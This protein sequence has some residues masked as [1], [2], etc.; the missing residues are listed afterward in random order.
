VPARNHRI[1]AFCFVA[2]LAACVFGYHPVRTPV[3]LDNQT[4]FY[5][6]ERAASGVPP[7]VSVV[8]HKHALSHLLSAGAIVAGR[9]A[10][11]DDV[12]AARALSIAACAGTVA[13]VAALALR[14]T[15][16]SAAGFLAGLAMLT[17]SGFLRQATMGFRP[18]LFATLFL[19]WAVVAACDRKHARA[20]AY[21]ACAFL[22]WQPAGVVI[23][24]LA[25]A[26]AFENRARTYVGRILA[27][28]GA[29]LASYELYFVFY[30][31]AHEQLFQTWVMA[32]YGTLEHRP[33]V[34]ATLRFLLQPDAGASLADSVVPASLFV[35]S[36]WLG[37]RYVR[38]PAGVI[39]LWNAR[40]DVRAVVLT[41]IGCVGFTFLDHQAYPDK[42][43]L[44]P[45]MSISYALLFRGLAACGQRRMRQGTVTATL[46][47]ADRTGNHS[48]G[49]YR[50]RALLASCTLF[51]TVLAVRGT[52]NYRVHGDELGAQRQLA[53]RVR[54]TDGGTASIWAVG[55]LHLLAFDHQPN[56]SPFGMLL[57]ERVRRYAGPDF[58]PLSDG[59][60]PRVILWA[61]A[62][63]FRFTWLEDEYEERTPPA[64]ARES[65]RV[66]IRKR[67][68]SDVGGPSP[69]IPG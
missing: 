36:G 28:A 15:A 62:G 64:F 53:A 13:L 56:Y 42:F 11:V 34:P 40:A 29:M 24:A 47:V 10:G 12:F 52:G 22:C 31:A 45:F 8:N 48:L 14:L 26:A 16:D 2:T 6:A 69:E 1:P 43:V 38:R 44:L 59:R 61:R 41:A 18:Q 35:L 21:G 17:F 30:R 50:R 5:I 66:W 7:H 63:K 9:A 19:A 33:W 27:G 46:G 4:F 20:G 65:I 67:Q 39:D 32:S 54:S 51:L 55:C 23:A 57:D 37:L 3:E 49:S 58:R 60:M 25:T 68:F